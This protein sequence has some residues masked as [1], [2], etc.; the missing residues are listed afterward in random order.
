MQPARGSRAVG[1]CLWPGPRGQDTGP[2]AVPSC[3]HG[4]LGGCLQRGP[5]FSDS[6]CR[7]GGRR[8]EILPGLWEQALAS[9]VS[10]N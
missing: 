3:R 4:T 5:R 6:V 2:R 1:G 10:C 9:R 8:G 7:Q